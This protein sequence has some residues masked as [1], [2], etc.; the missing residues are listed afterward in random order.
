MMVSEILKVIFGIYLLLLPATI[1]LQELSLFDYVGKYADVQI[2][3][4]SSFKALLKK[5]DKYEPARIRIRADQ[6][7]LLDT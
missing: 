7:I 2:E 3:I 6:E 1:Y 5:S 4:E